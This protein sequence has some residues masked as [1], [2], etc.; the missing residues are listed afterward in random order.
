MQP[1]DNIQIWPIQC[2]KG[3]G[4]APLE[5]H[6]ARI[7]VPTGARWMLMTDVSSL[8][9]KAVTSIRDICA[10]KKYPLLV[11]TH[12]TFLAQLKDHGVVKA[13]AASVALI[14]LTDVHKLA[15]DVRAPE[16]LLQSIRHL[17]ATALDPPPQRHVASKAT[18][19]SSAGTALTIYNK[20][21]RYLFPS[22]LPVVDLLPEQRVAKYALEDPPRRVRDDIQEF[23]LW[24]ALPVNLERSERYAS[25]VQST[26]LEKVPQKI[27]GY[28][29]YISRKY[30]I[31]KLDIDMALFDNPKY[32]VDFVAYLIARDVGLGHLR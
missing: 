21:E 27:L 22:T 28:L 16:V 3:R 32:C 12:A 8:L 26:T 4:F 25:G 9:G 14:R 30:A 11:S 23:L 15:V 20:Y 13:H 17:I 19:P 7:S 1:Y 24:S 6:L 18:Q 31:N 2:E 5:T 29:G 10:Q